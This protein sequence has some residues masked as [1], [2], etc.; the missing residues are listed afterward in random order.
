MK[1]SRRNPAPQAGGIEMKYLVIYEKVAENGTP[2]ATTEY[3][4]V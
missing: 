3:I 2:S 4:T 1:G